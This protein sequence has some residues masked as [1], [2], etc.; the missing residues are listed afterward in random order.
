ME[1]EKFKKFLFENRQRFLTN[2]YIDLETFTTQYM[3]G[4][5]ILN[6]LLKPKDVHLY[7]KEIA[8]TD[9]AKDLFLSWLNK[10]IDKSYD[11]WSGE[12][13]RAF[14]RAYYGK[15]LYSLEDFDDI[16]V[17]YC[18]MFEIICYYYYAFYKAEFDE[19]LMKGQEILDILNGKEE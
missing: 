9:N 18:S 3:V 5:E 6:K 10:N 12:E 16:S 4:N 14:F 7:L 15:L 1:N 11:V 17:K 19:M 2:G 8:P 13:F